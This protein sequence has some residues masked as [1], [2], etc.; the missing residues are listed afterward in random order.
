MKQWT[1]TGVSIIYY[2]G[3]SF[4]E[5]EQLWNYRDQL[6]S[7]FLWGG[8]ADG[9]SNFRRQKL[10]KLRTGK[11]FNKTQHVK[12]QT[13]AVFKGLSELKDKIILFVEYLCNLNDN[14]KSK[15]IRFVKSKTVKIFRYKINFFFLRARVSASTLVYIHTAAEVMKIVKLNR[16]NTVCNQ[17][18]I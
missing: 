5:T 14:L 13:G 18:Q 10:R 11:V 4:D 9:L 2:S 7:L 17:L 6:E 15:D 8:A 16:S 12:Q 1:R 3:Y